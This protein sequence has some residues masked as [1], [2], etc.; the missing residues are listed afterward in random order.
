MARP[1]RLWSRGSDTQIKRERE[2]ERETASLQIFFTG[3]C[4]SRKYQET[5]KRDVAKDLPE[6]LRERAR[7]RER[8]RMFSVYLHACLHIAKRPRS[9][10]VSDGPSTRVQTQLSAGW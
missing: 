9:W 8:E 5:E 2:E 3:R 6:G 1:L 10:M 4:T 7:V